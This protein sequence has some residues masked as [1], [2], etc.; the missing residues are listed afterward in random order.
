MV[1]NKAMIFKKIPTGMPVAGEHITVETREF[2]PS[3]AAPPGGLV[4]KNHHLS[5]DPFMRGQM[6]DPSVKSYSTPWILDQ[7][8]LCA[9]ISTVLASDREGIS[10]NDLVFAMSSASEYSIVPAP[11]SRM[12]RVLKNPPG[13]EIPP[14][15]LLG[16]LGTPGWTAYASFYEYL[17]PEEGQTFFVSAASGGVGQVVGQIAKMHGMKVIG[18]VGS[19]EKAKFVVD[20][21]GFDSAFIYKNESTKAA[22]QRLAPDGIDVYY[23]NVGG[24]QLDDTLTMMTKSG[25]VGM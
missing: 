4:L 8:A 16:A 9:T 13:M 17:Q 10:P 22:L 15:T 7:P 24:E 18:S 19:E 3:I 20:E 5:L 12:T 21:L 25:T 1:A 14:S 2:D 23:D 6:R 11:A